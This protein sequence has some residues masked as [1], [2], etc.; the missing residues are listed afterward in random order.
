ML[1]RPIMF[2][3]PEILLPILE[4]LSES[5]L[6]SCALV[7][8]SWV[9]PSRSYGFRLIRLD[10]DATRPGSAL[11]FLT[12]CNSPF[13]TFTA[14]GIRTLVIKHYTRWTTRAQEMTLDQLWEWRS[15]RQQTVHINYIFKC[16]VSS[17][18]LSRLAPIRI[19]PF[20]DIRCC[21]GTAFL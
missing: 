12:L 9:S 3:P 17:S 10:L 6:R 21:Q 16:E 5:N 14:A 8:R 7:C 15:P 18:A 4:G 20:D 19:F 2:L 13:E 1:T 11:R